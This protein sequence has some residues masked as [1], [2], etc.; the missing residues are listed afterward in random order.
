MKA[1]TFASEHVRELYEKMVKLGYNSISEEIRS[2]YG[3]GS[4]LNC[5]GNHIYIGSSF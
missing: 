3:S 4:Y 5:D 2:T 1:L